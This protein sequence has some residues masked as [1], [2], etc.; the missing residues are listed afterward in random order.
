MRVGGSQL[1]EADVR[2][3]AATNKNLEEEIQK[4]SF[5]EDLFYR[6]NVIPIV[7]P[8]LRTR[9]E[10]IPLLLKHFL[11]KK[12]LAH[13]LPMKSI[14]P[15]AIEVLIQHDWPGNVREMENMIEQMSALAASDQIDLNDIPA[16]IRRGSNRAPAAGA[17]PLGEMTLEQ[18]VERLERQMISQAL[19]QT[20]QVQTR[21]AKLLGITRRQL[22][23]KMDALGL[24]EK[25]EGGEPEEPQS[26]IMGD[27]E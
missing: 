25:Y 2:L 14:T 13:R 15:S 3:I 6:I 23:Y 26:G 12:S 10:D 20:R 8:P 4:G 9:K 17:I 18:A 27:H 16:A 22:K 1:L 24:T 5:R 7:L 21:A 19:H 11:E